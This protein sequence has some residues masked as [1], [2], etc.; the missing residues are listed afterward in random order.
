MPKTKIRNSFQKAAHRKGEQRVSGDEIDYLVKLSRSADAA[1]RLHAAEHLCPCHVRR[2]V[3]PV[4][5]ALFRMMEDENVKVRR[6]AWHTLE[7]GGRTDD[8]R[9]DVIA[10]RA[11]Q[12]ETDNQVRKF[13][14]AI[15]GPQLKVELTQMKNPASP[16]QKPKGKCDFCGR[17][18]VAVVT[19]IE[20]EIPD[21]GSSR[22]AL[23]CQDCF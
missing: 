21:A 20:T 3:E 12:S 16:A 18:N 15:A 14:E 6:A 1:E 4:W 13:V 2:H 17:Q 11:M 8:P 9:L 23:V 10:R 22:P 7:D 19:D 5:D